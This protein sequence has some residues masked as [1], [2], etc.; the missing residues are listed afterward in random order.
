MKEGIDDR[1]NENKDIEKW[2]EGGGHPR[3]WM[4]FMVFIEDF[5]GENAAVT[6][7]NSELMKPGFIYKLTSMSASD[8]TT[9]VSATI[10]I[11]HVR[12]GRF[13]ILKAAKPAAAI[14]V[15]WNGEIYL[16]EGDIIRA[17]FTNTTTGDDTFVHA[18][19]VKIPIKD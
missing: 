7:L 18:A 3:R 10:A 17:V 9:Q 8:I 5:E 12:G 15:N 1:M 2:V 11:G 13:H 14:T 19:G 4:P 6:T 16:R